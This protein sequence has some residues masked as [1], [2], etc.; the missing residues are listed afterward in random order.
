MGVGVRSS[1]DGSS[2][3]SCSIS[4]EWTICFSNKVRTSLTATTITPTLSRGASRIESF[5][6]ENWRGDS[7]QSRVE[8]A[9]SG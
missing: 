8:L 1:V 7:E 9:G 3:F 6:S 4:F 2:L 5:C